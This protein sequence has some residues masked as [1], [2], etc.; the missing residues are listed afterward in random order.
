MEFTAI[1]QIYDEHILPTYVRQEVCFTHGEGVTLYDTEGRAYLDFGSGI[2]VNSVGYAHPKW[3]TAV[4][5]QSA[6][7][8]HVSNLY[9][10]EPGG[11]LAEKLAALSG[12]QKV[13]FSN[14]GAEANEGLIKLA[15]KYSAD[16]YNDPKRYKIATL[17]K[18]FHGRTHTTLAATGQDV[19][20]AHF[21]P[22]TEGFIHLP[23]GDIDALKALGDDVCAV[24]LEPVQGE[25]GVIPLPEDY[26][27]AVS[28]LCAERDWLLLC[29]EV[30]TGIGRTGKWFGFQNAGVLPDAFS[31]AKGVAGGLPLGGFAVGEKALSVLTPGL[32]ATTFGGNPLCCAAALC[33]LEILE[34]AVPTVSERGEY[35]KTRLREMKLPAIRE[36]RGSGLM[37]G[38]SV[39]GDPK[40]L[41]KELLHKGLICLT[42]GSDAL[43]LLPPLII[44]KTDVD[45]G[46]DILQS[47]LKG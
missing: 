14:S 16:K 42:A 10:T 37:L 24:L 23:A 40:P 5:E 33:T 15:R 43:R 17:I 39:D 45:N 38:I 26:I 22:L 46:L 28:A 36:I 7:L 35:I 2:G 3:V 34:E 8:C 44:S 21:Q 19:F 11:L 27:R 31:F 30:Q 25:G 20:H 1:K 32:H 47:V 6:L 13:F 41:Q 9:Y 4:T 12:L 29:D 18:S